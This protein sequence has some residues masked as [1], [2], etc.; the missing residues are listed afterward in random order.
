MRLK[1]IGLFWEMIS[2]PPIAEGTEG[3]R[4]II[5]VVSSLSLVTGWG[6]MESF[7][8]AIIEGFI[9]MEDSANF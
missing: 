2:S 4:M 9:I 6:E 5:I 8:I 3:Q 1:D 7:T